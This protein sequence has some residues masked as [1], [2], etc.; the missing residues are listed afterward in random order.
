MSSHAV[1]KVAQRLDLLLA[2]SRRDRRRRTPPGTSRHGAPASRAASTCTLRPCSKRSGREPGL[3]DRARDPPAGLIELRQQIGA[4]AIVEDQSAGGAQFDAR[5][6]SQRCAARAT[7]CL[8]LEMRAQRRV[9][10]GRKLLERRA[11][12]ESQ[13]CDPRRRRLPRRRAMQAVQ[14]RVFAQPRCR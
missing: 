9:E 10:L 11:M 7:R 8:N 3:L 14:R 6:C 5:A 1:R 13:R 12:I 2:S 4:V